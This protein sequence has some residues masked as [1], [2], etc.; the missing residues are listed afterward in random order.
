[1]ASPTMSLTDAITETLECYDKI[2]KLRKSLFMRQR[3]S[4]MSRNTLMGKESALLQSCEVLLCELEETLRGNDTPHIR[5]Y[6][7]SE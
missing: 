2:R 1:M 4:D 6:I 5:N 3:G 7:R